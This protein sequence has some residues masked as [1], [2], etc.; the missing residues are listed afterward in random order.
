MSWLR[1]FKSAN[2]AHCSHREGQEREPRVGPSEKYAARRGSVADEMC[3]STSCVARALQRYTSPIYRHFL[4]TF[5]EV[6]PISKTR[7]QLNGNTRIT[8][9]RCRGFFGFGPWG[10]HLKRDILSPQSLSARACWRCR[11]QGNSSICANTLSKRS[12]NSRLKN[13]EAG[14]VPS[15]A[16]QSKL[17]NAVHTG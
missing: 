12:G 17:C 16:R 5:Q 2:T 11:G 4:L 10:I 7:N 13:R 1:V 3:M 15:E 9:P 8:H 14:V 6:I